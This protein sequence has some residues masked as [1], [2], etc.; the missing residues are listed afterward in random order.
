M[1]Q[2]FIYDTEGREVLPGS[3]WVKAID[4]ARINHGDDRL[5]GNEYIR[6]LGSALGGC[7]M[8]TDGAQISLA[9]FAERAVPPL[10]EREFSDLSWG[11]GAVITESQ[12]GVRV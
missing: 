4:I 10:T 7:A 8:V 11:Y 9:T 5:Y 6:A 1:K 2:L 12:K 3:D